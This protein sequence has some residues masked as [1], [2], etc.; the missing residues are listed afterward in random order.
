MLSIDFVPKIFE[1]N[2]PV[3]L[4]W[5][6]ETAASRLLCS[7]TIHF[8]RSMHANILRGQVK[9]QDCSMIKTSFKVLLTSSN[10]P[11]KIVMGKVEE[12]RLHIGL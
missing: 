3:D 10:N 1:L 9:E 11:E 8:S 2:L 4:E 6:D 5:I 12:E 7:V